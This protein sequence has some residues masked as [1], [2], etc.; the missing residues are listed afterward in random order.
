MQKIYNNFDIISNNVEPNSFIYEVVGDGYDWSDLKSSVESIGGETKML[1]ES[2]SVFNY[3]FDFSFI[4]N[5][6]S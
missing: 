1:E 4:G 5:K 2:S 6:N 3:L